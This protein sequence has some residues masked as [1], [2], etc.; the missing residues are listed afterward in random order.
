MVMTRADAF[1]LV[2]E[3][4]QNPALVKHLLAVE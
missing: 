1:A 2:A 4:T 3:F